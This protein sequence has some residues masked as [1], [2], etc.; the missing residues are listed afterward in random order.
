M[1]KKK[2]EEINEENYDDGVHEQIEDFLEDILFS[3]DCSKKHGN[4]YEY[5][6][7]ENKY[8]FTILENAFIILFHERDLPLE[9]LE[10]IFKDHPE[11]C[12]RMQNIIIGSIMERMSDENGELI[13]VKNDA[14]EYEG[15]M[16]KSVYNKIVGGDNDE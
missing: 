10:V 11:Y 6:N 13:E 5:D 9:L 3:V 8:I 15:H 7:E 14:G 1:P 16:L 4:Q 2:I 12:E